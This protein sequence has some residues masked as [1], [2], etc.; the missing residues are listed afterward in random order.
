M[1]LSLLK[2]NLIAA[3]CF[4]DFRVVKFETSLILVSTVLWNSA[5]CFRV[6]QTIQNGDLRIS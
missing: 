3:F 6:T 4:Q 1:V 5:R 2:T